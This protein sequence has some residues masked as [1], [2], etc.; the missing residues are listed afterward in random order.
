MFVFVGELGFCFFDIVF[1]FVF[2]IM[3]LICYGFFLVMYIFMVINVFNVCII[4]FLDLGNF[5][6]I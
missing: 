5:V 1:W 2:D 4:I 6:I 3:I